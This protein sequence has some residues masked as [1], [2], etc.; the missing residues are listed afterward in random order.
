M[1]MKGTAMNQPRR[2]K[3]QEG[4]MLLEALVAILIFSIGIIAV[5]GMQAASIAQVTQ[6]KFRTDASYLANQILGAMWVDLPN[7]PNYASSGYTGRTAWNAVVASTLP[8]GTAT[9]T[10]VGTATAVAPAVPPGAQVTVTITWQ[11]PEESV[12]HQYVASTLM[13]QS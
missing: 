8:Q 11:L 1:S 4:V 12:V 5:M 7:V 2:M 6:A 10:V 3:S 13:I 9:I